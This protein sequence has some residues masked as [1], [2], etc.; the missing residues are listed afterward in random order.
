MVTREIAFAND[1]LAG[2]GLSDDTSHYRNIT[3]PLLSGDYVCDWIEKNFFIPEQQHTSHP[4]LPLDPYQRAVIRE[5]HRQDD[6]GR[7]IYDLVLWSDIK[8]SAK[9]TIAAAVILCRAMHL[10]W[11][12]IRIV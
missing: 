12:G 8:K 5:A 11:G 9:S 3:S 4:A 10:S 6:R 7:Y 2:F 1:V